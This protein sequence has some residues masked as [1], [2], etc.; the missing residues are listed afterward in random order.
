V[1]V[2]R[3]N[4]Q[5]AYIR[6]NRS[7]GRVRISA[8]LH[9]D[10]EALRL[11]IAERLHWIRRQRRRAAERDEPPAPAMVSGEI[12]YVQGRPYELDVVEHA[13]RP[14]VRLMDDRVVELRCRPGAETAKRHA[15]LE[16][17]YRQRLKDA[18]SPLVRQWEPVMGVQVA[19]WR[20]KRMKTRWGSCSIGDRRIWLNLDLARR[21]PE[22]LEYVLVHEMV[23]LLERRHSPRFYAYLDRFLPEWRVYRERLN[24]APAIL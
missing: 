1:E 14:G 11:A 19:E 4:I 13:G 20:I 8:P 12:H 9:L 10:D 16:K 5:H 17:W 18:V 21:P 15:V 23:H 3:K 22:C 24:G 7:D 2:S 6:V